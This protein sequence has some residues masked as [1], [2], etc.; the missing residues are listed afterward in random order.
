EKVGL[1]EYQV[2]LISETRKKNLCGKMLRYRLLNL[3]QIPL[4]LRIV[5]MRFSENLKD[6]PLLKAWVLLKSGYDCVN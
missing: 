3:L 4:P 6:E 2:R 1:L 5:I